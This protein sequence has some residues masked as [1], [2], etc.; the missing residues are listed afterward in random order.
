MEEQ[1]LLDRL[2]QDLSR[3][4]EEHQRYVLAISQA[5]LF[6]QTVTPKPPPPP[7]KGR[8]QEEKT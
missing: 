1:T 5:L 4:N 7:A 8:E 2:N 3:L 6:A